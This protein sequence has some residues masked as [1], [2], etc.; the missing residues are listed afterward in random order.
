MLQ[1]GLDDGE[2]NCL[3]PSANPKKLE[4][5]LLLVTLHTHTQRERERVYNNERENNFSY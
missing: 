3:L 2:L 4:P 5:T 1:R